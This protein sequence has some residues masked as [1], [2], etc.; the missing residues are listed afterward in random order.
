MLTLRPFM[1]SHHVSHASSS[2]IVMHIFWV[3]LIFYQQQNVTV[4]FL[5]SLFESSSD[6][7]FSDNIEP[8]FTHWEGVLRGS[9][10]L[11]SQSSYLIVCVERKLYFQWLVDSLGNQTGIVTYLTEAW[12]FRDVSFLNL[13][14]VIFEKS[15]ITLKR[16][17][18]SQVYPESLN[19]HFENQQFH[20]HSRCQVCLS[21]STTNFVLEHS[22]TFPQI[23]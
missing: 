8:S 16:R 18:F 2:P 17:A 6:S 9:H 23:F 10:L 13:L 21:V 3:L 4:F 15:C 1:T 11:F 5:A 14:L 7:S 22:E 20:F 19:C 12:R